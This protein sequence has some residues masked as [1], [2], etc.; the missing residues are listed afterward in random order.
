VHPSAT[1]K[2]MLYSTNQYGRTT[3]SV[4]VSVP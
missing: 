3:D 2:Y 4:T 1:T